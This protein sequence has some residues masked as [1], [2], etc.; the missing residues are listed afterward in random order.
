MKYNLL[1]DPCI[2]VRLT[3]DNIL[4]LTLPGVLSALSRNEIE[5]FLALRSH[6]AHPWHAFLCQLAAMA[7]DLCS[8]Q[9]YPPLRGTPPHLLLGEHSEEEWKNILRTLT[10]Q[11]TFDEPWTMF[12]DDLSKPAFLQPPVPE[13]NL[14]AWKEES[15][16]DNMDVLVQS[17]NLGVKTGKV[18]EPNIDDWIFALLSLQTQA[19]FLGAGNYGIARQNGGFAT[20]PG[21][22]LCTDSHW[23][24]QWGRDTRSLIES[25]SEKKYKLDWDI[26]EGTR[27][28]WIEPWNGNESLSIQQLHPF[29]IE[30]ARRIRLQKK[31]EKIFVKYT[32]TKTPRI[33]A[34]ALKGNIEDPWIPIDMSTKGALNKR[35]NYE[36]MRNILFDRSTFSPCLLQEFYPCDKGNNFFIRFRMLSRKKGSTEEYLERVVYVPQEKKS[37]FEKKSELKK[38]SQTM[39][40]LAKNVENKVLW[41]SVISLYRIKQEEGKGKSGSCGKA[42]ATQVVKEFDSAVDLNFFSFLWDC[43]SIY[44]KDPTSP[45]VYLSPWVTFL[46]SEAE[47][48]FN[49][50]AKN[51]SLSGPRRYR[52]ISF[53]ENIFYG[54]IRKY[55]IV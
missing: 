39:I 34:K 24:G 41:F 43:L 31:R 4:P 19:A 42:E 45:Q 10:S 30:I 16:P 23:G 26:K 53:A 27:L 1:C 14:D 5:S 2:R 47:K 49:M 50:V 32:G 25:I 20:R 44:S 55:L 52:A 11:F 6:Q 37:L 38:I 22:A 48:Q 54:R 33:D 29:F 12:V 28:I 17:K 35:P 15:F 18:V 3:N 36:V 46:K 8:E 13:G 40:A 9:K 7:L 21:V 51:V